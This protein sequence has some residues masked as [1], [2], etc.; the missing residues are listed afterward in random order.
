MAHI[1]CALEGGGM[2]NK[3]ARCIGVVPFVCGRFFD[4]KKSRLRNLVINLTVK[5]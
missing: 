3:I 4:A 5:R 2:L 1:K